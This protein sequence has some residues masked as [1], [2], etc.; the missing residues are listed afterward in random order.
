MYILLKERSV[1]KITGEDRVKFLQ[2][3]LSNDITKIT[4]NTPI[5]ACM[6]TPQGKYFA[7]FFL[8]TRGQEIIFDIPTP[9]AEEIINKLNLYKLR[10]K[11]NISKS[12]D[13]NVVSIINEKIDNHLNHSIIYTDPRSV[14]LG[15]RCYIHTNDMDKLKNNLL[16]SINE[17]DKIRIDNF[18]PEGHKD[19]IP[20]KSFPFEYELDS[21]NAIDYNKG[22]YV[23]QELVARTYYRGQI[24]KKI[25]QIRANEKLP[26]LGTEIFLDNQKIGIVCSSIENI[27]LALVKTEATLEHNRENKITAD[28]LAIELIFKE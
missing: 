3:L 25:V 5:Y 6:L 1:F 18:I 21:L 14:I 28:N 16:Q 9:S 11:I 19:L 8:I 23:G 20:N 26:S 4:D 2:G 7:D 13:Y 24:R 17:Y 27:G 12:T 22:C 10:S 15:Y